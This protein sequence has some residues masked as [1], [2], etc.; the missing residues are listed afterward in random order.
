MSS[1]RSTYA[2]RY[3]FASFIHVALVFTATPFAPIDP[4]FVFNIPRE[5][6]D[7]VLRIAPEIFIKAVL[8]RSLNFVVW[9]ILL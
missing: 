3:N 9:L 8:I 6:F 4:D 5:L 7:S 1:P 2:Y